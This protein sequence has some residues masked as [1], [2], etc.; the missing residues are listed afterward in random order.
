MAQILTS[1]SVQS[2]KS[3]Q[4]CPTSAAYST[5]LQH[6]LPVTANKWWAGNWVFRVWCQKLPNCF[7]SLWTEESEVYPKKCQ[8]TQH[9]QRSLQLHSVSSYKQLYLGSRSFY[10]P[11]EK[12]VKACRRAEGINK[13][14]ILQ[15]KRK[16]TK[17]MVGYGWK[18]CVRGLTIQHFHSAFFWKNIVYEPLMQRLRKQEDF[19][20]VQWCI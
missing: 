8:S 15:G 4:P 10:Q 7:V 14:T 19:K 13:V 9:A 5:A 20:I 3:W 16:W 6:T 1:T 17:W 12:L 11:Y 18:S 2:K